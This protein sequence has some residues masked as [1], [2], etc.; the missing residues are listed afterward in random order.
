MIMLSLFSL[1]LSTGFILLMVS[2]PLSIG[3]LVLIS[4]F[5]MSICVFFDGGSWFG[6]ILFLI[7]IGGLLVMFAYITALTPN[8]VF[9]VGYSGFVFFMMYFFWMGL[10]F[11]MDVI[12]IFSEEES[13]L[14]LWESGSHKYGLTLFS[15]FGS[16]T[17]VGMVFILLFVL[18]CVVKICY[19]SKGALRPF[20]N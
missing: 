10:F 8:L 17:V 5:M 9:K 7:Y 18:L 15:F 20:S 16:I 11:T 19:K 13:A 12:N 6:F 1:I 2:Q 4:S 14:F 3:G